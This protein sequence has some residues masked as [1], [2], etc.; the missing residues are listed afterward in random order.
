M[1]RSTSLLTLGLAL[2]CAVFSSGVA[3]RV[4]A[5]TFKTLANFDSAGASPGPV[6]QGFNG[7]F[8]GTTP[9]DGEH[10]D[11]SIFEVTPQ[12]GLSGIYSFCSQAGCADGEFPWG[13]VQATDGNLYGTTQGTTSGPYGTVFK[14]TPTGELTTLHTFCSEKNCADGQNPYGGLIQAS[15]GNFY[16]ITFFGG[17]NL[18]VAGCYD[19]GCGVLFEVTPAGEFTVVY[20]FCSKPNCADGANPISTLVQG[21]N[22]N[23]YG[24]TFE[25]GAADAGTVFE[26]TP[27]G[28]LTTLYSFCARVS[29]CPDGQGPNGL[30]QAGDGNFY[31][32]TAYGGVT[33]YNNGTFFEINAA[34]KFSTLYSFCADGV[35]SDGANPNSGLMQGTSGKFYGTTYCGGLSNSCND[36]SYGPGTVFEI[37][38]TGTLT[39]IHYFCSET[40]CDDGQGPTASPV[41]GTSGKIYGTATFGGAYEDGT[42]FSLALGLE[43]FIKTLPTSGVV[44]ANVN[45]LGNNLVGTTSVTFNGVEAAFTVKSDTYIKATVPAG[46]STGGVSVV[47]PSGTLKSNPQFVV[48]K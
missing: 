19:M 42:F 13:L 16:G 12:G 39:T 7:N 37:S 32:T 24:V 3:V 9:M 34:G 26:V 31:G 30:V 5:Q 14:V 8:Y 18:D 15:N 46:A 40:N 6:V 22:G 1:K 47:T 28:K 44:G 2:A 35:C 48:S 33:G 27:A 10:G 45:I 36:F 38:S 29:S 4:Q 20:N 25:G 11:G 23:F 21:S 17:A 43:P 41:Q